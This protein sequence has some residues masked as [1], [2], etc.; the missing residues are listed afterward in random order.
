MIAGTAKPKRRPPSIND[1]FRREWL[2]HGVAWLILIV[3][4]VAATFCVPV[5]GTG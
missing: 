2:R 5:A 1:H 3:A 4:G